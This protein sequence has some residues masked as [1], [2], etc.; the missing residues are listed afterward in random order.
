MEGAYEVAQLEISN[1]LRRESAMLSWSFLEAKSKSRTII[2]RHYLI[3]SEILF[4]PLFPHKENKSPS[5]HY[6]ARPPTTQA[7]KSS[8]K[9]DG[10]S[11]FLLHQHKLKQ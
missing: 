8:P 7:W 4:S 5:T 10:L 9:E 11:S 3:K 1:H 2:S 6:P